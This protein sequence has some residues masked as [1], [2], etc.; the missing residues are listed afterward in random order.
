MAQQSG[1]EVGRDSS[2]EVGKEAAQKYFAP[3]DTA[4]P[5]A[6]NYN[7]AKRT[8]A[9][10]VGGYFESKAYKWGN[11]S[12][13]EKAGLQTIGVTYKVGEW[14]D[15]MDLNLRVEYLQYEFDNQGKPIKL[16]FLPL[17]T[18]PDAAA[19][20]PLYFG[21]GLGPGIFISQLEDESNITLDYQLVFGVRVMDLFGRGGFIL[22]AGV[23]DHLHVLS[24]GQFMG[25]FLSLGAVFSI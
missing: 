13:Y 8:L 7:P 5:S 15:S 2:K 14:T 21:A 19:N 23:K 17:V 12:P 3:S 16:S 9:L 22:E 4:Q 18:F 24:D 20:F 11:K 25:Q 1:Q 6:Q 10:M